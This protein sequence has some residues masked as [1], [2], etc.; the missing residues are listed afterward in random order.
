[1]EKVYSSF[2]LRQFCF[3]RKIAEFYREKGYSLFTENNHQDFL[4]KILI[5]FLNQEIEREQ[6]LRFLI[7]KADS[8]CTEKI[9]FDVSLIEKNH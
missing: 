8:F 6:L 1:M 2:L 3:T 7:V 9:R 4:L 5:N